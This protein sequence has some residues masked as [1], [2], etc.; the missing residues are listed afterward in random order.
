MVDR[1][2]RNLCAL[3]RDLCV[4]RVSISY[5][6]T[7]CDL[8][9]LCGSISQ[10]VKLRG[11]H[12]F[13]G[14]SISRRVASRRTSYIDNFLQQPR[15][16]P[17]LEDSHLGCHGKRASSLFFTPKKACIARAFI[18]HKDLKEHKRRSPEFLTLCDLCALCG[19][20]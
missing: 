2:F 1:N 16:L 11:S 18:N 8:C 13:C 3:L 4:L 6:L 20:I 15:W 5:N 12:F 10:N 14:K 19:S 17:S 7:L 9:V